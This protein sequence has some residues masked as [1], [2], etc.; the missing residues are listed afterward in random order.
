[1]Q[2][3][4]QCTEISK[5]VNGE[6][7]TVRSNFKTV[8]S[9][10]PQGSIL[11]PLLFL[12]YIND[13]PDVTTH[14]CILFA[15]D[16]TILFKCND[17]ENFEK[18]IN[19]T[20]KDIVKWMD[21]NNLKLNISKTKAIQFKT[22]KGK[23]LELD[24]NYEGNKIELIDSTDFL[25]ITLD[26]NLNWKQ[27]IDT[28]CKKINKFVYALYKLRRTVSLETA[29]KAYHGYVSSVLRYG[30][31]IWGNS[32]S[33]DR[34][35]KAQKKCIR[36]LCNIKYRDSCRPM[37]QKLNILPLPCLYV[38]EICLFVN[39]YPN[40]FRTVAQGNPNARSTR[41]NKLHITKSKLAYYRNNA[42]GMAIKLYNKIPIHIINLPKKKFPNA[43]LKW[44]G[45][46]NFYSV[47]E[48]LAHT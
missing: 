7:I 25:G 32:V 48:F 22:Y 43:L 41:L 31:V 12:L 3:R 14:K 5:K 18:D 46:N 23:Q 13:L 2:N 39:K 17:R 35:F 20:L 21:I 4:Q 33:L 19:S 47:Q 15:D 36:A 10:V 37:F 34:A 29:L 27:H 30:I 9:G 1:M 42:M 8:G 28:L 24:I 44:L 26:Q 16:T 45:E 11:G 6:K 40:F 38:A